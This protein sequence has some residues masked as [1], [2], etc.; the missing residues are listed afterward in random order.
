L[1]VATVAFAGRLDP[2][3]LRWRVEATAP[4]GATYD[5]RF[6]PFEGHLVGLTRT[7]G[8]Q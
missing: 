6:E 7:G 3:A 2:G 8:G 1:T 4:D 5:L